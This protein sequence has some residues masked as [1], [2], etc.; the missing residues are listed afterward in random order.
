MQPGAAA[1]GSIVVKNDDYFIHIKKKKNLQICIS[2]R[3]YGGWARKRR[4]GAR[5]I[6]FPRLSR[7]LRIRD[8]EERTHLMSTSELRKMPFGRNGKWHCLYERERGEGE[9]ARESKM[10]R[11]KGQL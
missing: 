4:V 3:R 6:F 5:A 9:R 10:E 7:D 11:G 8:S 2:I 1:N